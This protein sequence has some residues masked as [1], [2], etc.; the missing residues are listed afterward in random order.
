MRAWQTR[1]EERLKRRREEFL[2]RHPGP[3]AERAYSAATLALWRCATPRVLAHCRGLV[4]DAGAGTG[5]WK[6]IIEAAGGVY[7][8][9]DRAPRGAHVPTWIGDLCAMPQ[10]PSARFDAAV[11]HQVL[12]HLCDP[13]AAALELARVLRPGGALVVS[14]PH[15]SR[16]HELPDD[17]FRFTARGLESLFSRAGLVT[18]E[19]APYGGPASLAHHQASLVYHGLT[20]GLPG[21]EWAAVGLNALWGGLAV[22]LDDLAFGRLLPLGIVAVF[23]KPTGASP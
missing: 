3:R 13:W 19:I 1:L 15:L 23:R 8:S 14:A 5:A 2:E 22:A 9:L 17:Y 6:P 11:C 20:P 10:V 7:E 21:L 16:Y 4:L 12:E 18:V